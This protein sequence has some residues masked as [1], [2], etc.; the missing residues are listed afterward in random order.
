MRNTLTGMSLAG[1]ALLIAVQVSGTSATETQPAERKVSEPS[2]VAAN[3][4]LRFVA[5]Q[6]TPDTALLVSTANK[7]HIV[8]RDTSIVTW[9]SREFITGIEMGNTKLTKGIHPGKHVWLPIDDVTLM[10]S[11]EINELKA[12]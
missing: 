7:H 6:D 10:A 2:P 11:I 3:D 1:V 4:Q 5:L 9:G 12:D 8:L